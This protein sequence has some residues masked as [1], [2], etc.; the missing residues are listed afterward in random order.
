MS[1]LSPYDPAR[2]AALGLDFMV[3]VR[4]IEDRGRA[5]YGIYMADGTQLAVMDSRDLAFAASI[6]QDM[7]ALSVH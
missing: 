7:K 2:F 4:P 3:Y 6:Q 5:A 1:I